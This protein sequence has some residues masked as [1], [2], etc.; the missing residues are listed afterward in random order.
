MPILLQRCVLSQVRNIYNLSELNSSISDSDS[1]RTVSS[2]EQHV[3]YVLTYL[4]S[5]LLH[6]TEEKRVL[7]AGI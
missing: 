2:T 6:D 1:R 4:T 3:P 5:W 7:L